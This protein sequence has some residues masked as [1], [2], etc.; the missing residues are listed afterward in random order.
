MR[1]VLNRKIVEQNRPAT[2]SHK[3]Q[4]CSWHVFP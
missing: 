4:F 1:K 3:G 2:Q